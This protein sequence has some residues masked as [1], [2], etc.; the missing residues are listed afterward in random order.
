M[1]LVLAQENRFYL[2]PIH[3]FSLPELTT[4]WNVDVLGNCYIVSEDE[5]TKY[6]SLGRRKYV[7]SIKSIGEVQAIAIM[8]TMRIAL[9]SE[10]QQVVCFFDNTLTPGD[11][12]L[13]LNELELSNVTL[14]S[15]SVQSDKFWFYDAV[16]SVVRKYSLQSGGG[17]IQEQEL[18]NFKGLTGASELI[19]MK[20]IDNN[21][22]LCCS[23][24]TLIQIDQFGSLK[25]KFDHI[26]SQFDLSADFIFTQSANGLLVTDIKNNTTS[27][28]TCD[29]PSFDS[30]RVVGKNIYFKGVDKIFKYQL[31][32][33]N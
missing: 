30:F 3:E 14:V 26:S 13:D 27:T 16:N 9:F 10:D 1:T 23:D 20:E 22:F 31:M 19:W 4:K 17:F 7:Q 28:I 11:D 18:I 6:D 12:C 21:L 24:G 25:R 8:N 29:L 33:G 5:I 32:N 15:T 2:K